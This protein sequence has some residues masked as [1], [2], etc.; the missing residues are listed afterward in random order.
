MSDG[1]RVHVGIRIVRMH[2]ILVD[3]SRVTY[4]HTHTHTHAQPLVGLCSAVGSPWVF[5]KEG[6]SADP[7]FSWRRI[8]PH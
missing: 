7:P 3:K 6:V 4:I 8:P 1:G 5:Q 2:E